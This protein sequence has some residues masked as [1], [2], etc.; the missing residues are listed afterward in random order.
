[1][2]TDRKEVLDQWNQMSRQALDSFKE[3]GEINARTTSRIFQQQVEFLNALVE[4]GLRR[5]NSVYD[6]KIYRQALE[7]QTALAG[8]INEKF[9]SSARKTNE[10]LVESNNELNAW[11]EKSA[12]QIAEQ[13]QQTMDK[14]QQ[15]V[16][17]QTRKATEQGKDA[18]RQGEEA[19]QQ[20]G[21]DAQTRESR[22]AT[23][24]KK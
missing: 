4:A 22:T 24:G 12:R 5:M 13:A 3:L 15:V 9:L 17:E 14:T 8:E 11:A 18:V 16:E 7:T 10:V 23:A 1:M 2:A 21:R 6:P 20:N 19:L